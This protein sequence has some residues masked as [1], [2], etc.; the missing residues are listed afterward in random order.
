MQARG[1]IISLSV[2][3]IVSGCASVTVQRVPNADIVNLG[4][5]Y[6]IHFSPEKRHLERIISDQLNFRGFTSTYGEEQ[7]MPKDI[8]TMVTYVDHWF[9]DITNYML[10]ITIEFR[11]AKTKA[12]IASGKSYRPSLQRSTPEKM[13]IETID[14]IFGNRT[15]PKGLDADANGRKIIGWRVD[16]SRKGPNGQ[17][18]KVPVYEDEKK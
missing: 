16:T 1:I 18:L 10:D 14:K 2:I 15:I 13:I 12:L 11:D 9:W 17:F 6:V 3:A 4:K 8:D 5:V 7:D